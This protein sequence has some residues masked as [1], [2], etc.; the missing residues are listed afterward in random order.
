MYEMKTR[1]RFSQC[2]MNQFLSKA[3][4]LDY[5][6]DCCNL[7]S[8]FGNVDADHMM[9]NNLVWILSAWNVVINRMPKAFDEVA[10][11]TWPYEFKGF[12]GMRNFKLVDANGEVLAYADTTWTLF[13]IAA[14]RPVKASK[15]LIEHYE[16]EEPFPMEHVGRKLAE[17]AESELV[18]S[19]VVRKHHLDV[20]QHMNN[21]QYV[22]EAYN[23]V[24]DDFDL[25]RILV[26]YR[27]Q[28]IL[29]EKIDFYKTIDSNCVT[30]VMKDSE[31][32]V[33]AIVKFD[34]KT[35]V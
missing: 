13:D 8:Y 2:D 35:E 18:D 4:L 33:H 3:A 16:L 7:Q 27:K 14:G 12:F 29:N 34:G 1:V 23:Y 32:A 31:G 20:N 26:E 30:I 10:V 6:Q 11:Y 21:A 25:K 9:A 24:P 15:E 28:T 5:F 22:R 19:M 17:P